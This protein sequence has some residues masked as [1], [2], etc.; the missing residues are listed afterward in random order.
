MPYGSILEALGI[1]RFAGSVSRASSSLRSKGVQFH[2][3][4]PPGGEKISVE[5]GSVRISYYAGNVLVDQRRLKAQGVEI[6]RW[7]KSNGLCM[8]VV[9]RSGGRRIEVGQALSPNDRHGLISQL[10]KALA[11]QGSDY[12]LVA[13]RCNGKLDYG[14]EKSL[15]KLPIGLN[16]ASMFVSKLK[17]TTK[18]LLR[19]RGA[20][21]ASAMMVSVGITL[22]IAFSTRQIDANA[23][24]RQPRAIFH[25]RGEDGSSI[26]HL[27]MRGAPYAIFFGYAHCQAICAETMMEMTALIRDVGGAGVGFRIFFVT[28]DPQRDTPDVLAEFL[29]PFRPYAI[30]LSGSSTEIDSAAGALRVYYA[31]HSGSDEIEHSTLVYLVDAG[32]EV[33]DVVASQAPHEQTRQKLRMLLSRTRL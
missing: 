29:S 11:Q 4:A 32:G 26:S 24:P 9:L 13:R 1:I 17:R 21:S 2:V 5:R 28:L 20:C 16:A 10:A 18:I 8:R 14:L 19:A 3:G 12:S 25:L 15:I 33:V 7:S 30:G 23:S 27:T 31:R 22:A 6:E